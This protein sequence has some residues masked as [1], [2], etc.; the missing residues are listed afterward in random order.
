MASGSFL[1]KGVFVCE[2]G[3]EREL[4]RRSPWDHAVAEAFVLL[5]VRENNKRGERER[6]REREGEG[7]GEGVRDR[8][9]EK[10]RGS[11]RCAMV[12][13]FSLALSLVFFSLSLFV[14][15]R[16]LFSP[17]H[18][19][20]SLSHLSRLLIYIPY[21]THRSYLDISTMI[22]SIFFFSPASS[23]SSFS[24][25]PLS[26]C[27][28]LSSLLLSL[29][30]RERA[31][32]DCGKLFVERRFLALQSCSPLYLLHLFSCNF[33]LVKQKQDCEFSSA[34]IQT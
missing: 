22:W 34:V 3:W 32:N 20:F 4:W 2:K 14:V 25:S 28:V 17:T 6:E 33:R 7:E 31:N 9:R 27:F 30:E 8:E 23:L 13:Y 26:S 29:R 16:S 19:T 5:A 11:T 12:Y 21:Y 15:T 10:E 24:L 1:K 18:L